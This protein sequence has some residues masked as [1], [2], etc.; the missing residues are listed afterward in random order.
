[1]KT[2]SALFNFIAVWIIIIMLTVLY[3][4]VD[5]IQ[6]DYDTAVLRQ[7]IEYA[8]EAAFNSAVVQS[9]DI[10]MDYTKLGKVQLYTSEALR[11]FEDIVCLSYG[12]SLSAENRAHIESLIPSAILCTYDGYYITKLA[13]DNVAELK[14]SLKIP[15]TIEAKR[16]GKTSTV[17]IRMDSEENFVIDNDDTTGKVKPYKSYGNGEDGAGFQDSE[18][19][20]D[21]ARARINTII[22]NALSHN[23][24][25]I[26]A[27]RGG[28][29]YRVYLPAETTFTGINTIDGPSLIILLEGGDF[30]GKAKVSEAAI[31]GLKVVRKRWV[32]GFKD[33]E[34]N[35]WY[36]YESQLTDEVLSDP[37]I[38]VNDRPFSSPLD[39][40]LSGYKPHFKLL[41]TDING[42]G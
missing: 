17:A 20:R 39:A 25:Q 35:L 3:R 28:K 1:M 41:A 40:A 19:N 10:G 26:S 23:I 9:G 13:D 31:S 33:A 2:W 36:C 27:D 38:Q 7:V 16:N 5:A 21:I 32:M 8:G 24:S 29:N 18:L 42:G 34:G 37:N 15:Y 30:A 22:T 4:H 11:V 6:A 12:M 14:W